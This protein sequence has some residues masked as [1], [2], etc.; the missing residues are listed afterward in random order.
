MRISLLLVALST[1][2]ACDSAPSSFDTE[3][4]PAEGVIT[5][6]ANGVAFTDSLQ[7]RNSAEFGLFLDAGLPLVQADLCGLR[8]LFLLD[9]QPGVQDLR[10]RRFED[11]RDNRGLLVSDGY[12]DVVCTEFEP[13]DAE[14]NRI[15]LSEG[16]RP[17]EFTG[18]FSVTLIQIRGDWEAGPDTLRIEDGRITFSVGAPE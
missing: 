4:D 3:L 14:S 15:V 12:G 1:L 8:A 5:G 13:T 2:A 16:V 9:A 18:V 6:S 11:N 7:A 17:G 10:L